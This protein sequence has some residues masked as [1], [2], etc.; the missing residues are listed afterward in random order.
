[1]C[2]SCYSDDG[3]RGGRTIAR[4]QTH[5]TTPHHTTPPRAPRPAHRHHRPHLLFPPTMAMAGQSHSRPRKKYVPPIGF[6][7][8]LFLLFNILDRNAIHPGTEDELIYD[9]HNENQESSLVEW[10][11]MPSWRSALWKITEK[12]DLS[13]TCRMTCRDMSP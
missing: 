13:V 4:T 6:I 7:L 1:M 5:H 12:P 3:A 10:I 11:E 8:I 2:Y 9:N